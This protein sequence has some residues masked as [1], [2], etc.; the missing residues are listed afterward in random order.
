MDAAAKQS[1]L[2][3]HAVSYKQT[4]NGEVWREILPKPIFLADAPYKLYINRSNNF[5]GGGGGGG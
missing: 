1:C 3:S 4:S 2:L 5:R